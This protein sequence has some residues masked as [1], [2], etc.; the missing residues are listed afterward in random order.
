MPKVDYQTLSDPDLIAASVDRQDVQAWEALILRYQRLIY[1]IPL[2]MGLPQ[3]DAGDIFQNVCILL[4][5]NLARLRDRARLGPWLAIT[6]R[7]EAWRFMRLHKAD[8]N[9]TSV[10]LLELKSDLTLEE[11]LI[12]LER[13][14]M[15]HTAI[16]N[17]GPRCQHLLTLL[18][19]TEPKP[20]YDDITH[21]LSVPLG[22]IGPLR[23]RCMERLAAVL[24][25]L[26]LWD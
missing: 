26:G 17:L 24:Q 11:D 6:A 20:S 23:A 25:R 5:E 13:Q 10:G 7:R 8:A 2:A 14:A 19:L 16:E 21:E 3:S 12:F 4:L 1:S 15:V 18:F 9:S 22:S